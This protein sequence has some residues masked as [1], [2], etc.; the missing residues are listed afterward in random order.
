MPK[1]NIPRLPW[2]GGSEKKESEG[3]YQRGHSPLLFMPPLRGRAK[4]FG[5]VRL[6]VLIFGS[7]SQP[8]DFFYPLRNKGSLP[9][10]GSN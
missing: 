5:W 2:I 1:Q 7:H 3:G 10:N 9:H 4:S 8:K 6:A